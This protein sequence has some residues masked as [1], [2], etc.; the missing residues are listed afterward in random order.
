M[1]RPMPART[2]RMTIKGFILMEIVGLGHV[3]HFAV[4]MRQCTP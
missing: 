2:P 3:L 4:K 1:A